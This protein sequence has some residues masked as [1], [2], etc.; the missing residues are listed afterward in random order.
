MINNSLLKLPFF[1]GFVG[2]N[3]ISLSYPMIS[4]SLIPNP[5]IESSVLPEN[6]LFQ[7]P[8]LTNI[9]RAIVVNKLLCVI[10]IDSEPRYFT[11]S[12]LVL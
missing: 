9:P 7:I 3:S 1:Q 8:N 11:F 4:I 2:N 10:K 12:C 5:G 6:I